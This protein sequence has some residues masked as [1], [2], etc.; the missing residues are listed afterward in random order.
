MLQQS[1]L[2]EQA[3]FPSCHASTIAEL[4]DRSLVAAWF[5]GKEEG[6]PDVGIWLSRKTGD[7]WTAPAQVAAGDGVPCWN[8]VLHQLRRGPLLLFYKMGPSPQT[9]S[10]LVQRSSDGGK[11]WSHPEMLPPGILGPIKNKP[12]ELPDGTL[13]CG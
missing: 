5:G 2:F 9:W 7:R 3:P 12:F 13:V 4:P 1:F 6:A 11:S 10:G 8:P